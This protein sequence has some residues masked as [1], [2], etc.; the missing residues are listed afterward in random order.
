MLELE[1]Q[2]LIELADLSLRIEILHGSLDETLGNLERG[3]D[4]D[5]RRR[6][7]IEDRDRAGHEGRKKIDHSDGD[8]QLVLTVRSYQSFCSTLLR[9]P[10]RQAPL[11]TTPA[12]RAI[13]CKS[14][15]SFLRTSLLASFPH[16][17]SFCWEL[18]QESRGKTQCMSEVA[19]SNGKPGNTI[20]DFPIN[21]G[22]LADKD[23]VPRSL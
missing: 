1:R 7:G 21:I 9:S 8:E 16:F 22:T 18:W 11:Q 14:R 20:A 17:P 2:L 3:F 4:L 5:P 23:A 15:S 19:K 6:T 12:T 13:L 10:R